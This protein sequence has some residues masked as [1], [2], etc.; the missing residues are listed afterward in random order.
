[1]IENEEQV[2]IFLQSSG[3][4]LC[5]TKI[6]WNAIQKS[7]KGLKL[8]KYNL[9]CQEQAHHGAAGNETH[10][11]HFD[12]PIWIAIWIWTPSHN[13]VNIQQFQTG[14]PVLTLDNVC[15]VVKNK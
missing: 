4:T 10:A 8:I 12:C 5:L 3:G 7:L 2:K 13:G 14:E 1:M 6:T 11:S 9:K 15:G